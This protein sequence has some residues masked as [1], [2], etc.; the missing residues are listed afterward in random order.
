MVR[1]ARL[2]V[3]SLALASV[4]GGVAGCGSAKR[5]P[6]PDPASVVPANAA[7]YL[8]AVVRPQGTLKTLAVADLRKL[9]GSAALFG[10]LYGAL[11]LRGAG[12][13]AVAAAQVDPWLGERAGIYLRTLPPGG[14][15]GLRA[16]LGVVR[17]ALDGS[18][19]A[20]SGGGEGESR[21]S[22]DGAFVVDTTNAAR[23]QAFI[24]AQSAGT[25]H[26]GTEVLGIPVTVEH[27]G[28]AA[29]IVHGFLV[30]GSQAG[31]K[32]VIETAQGASALP[33]APG[34][35]ILHQTAPTGAL[36]HLYVSVP[37]SAGQ[38]GQSAARARSA[39]TAS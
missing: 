12:G 29:A 7:L 24:A 32:G 25:Q 11:S 8:G 33:S 38:T 14:T 22:P 28:E 31:V 17:A 30:I 3:L 19:F 20:G 9:T 34:Y 16:L 18:L 6:A 10:S 36:A 35:S 21:G 5:P 15:S 39:S 37:R 23:A 26:T 27:D 2:M 13:G 4:V 1:S